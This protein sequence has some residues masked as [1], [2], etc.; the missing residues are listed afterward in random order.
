MV[1]F[2][3]ASSLHVLGLSFNDKKKKTKT[4]D[5]HHYICALP[6]LTALL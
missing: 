2:Q 6:H 4:L 5:L 1:P 3:T